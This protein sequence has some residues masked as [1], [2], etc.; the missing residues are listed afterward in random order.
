M[1]SVSKTS[2]RGPSVPLPST[3]LTLEPQQIVRT[4]EALRDRINER[5]PGSGLGRIAQ[6]L[7]DVAG[8]TVQRLQWVAT[9]HLPLRI[10]VGSL[11]AR[12]L[13]PLCP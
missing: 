3:R 5:F 2:L 1:S 13:A 11:I 6:D 9:P 12:L 10:A 7:V 8:G 4:C